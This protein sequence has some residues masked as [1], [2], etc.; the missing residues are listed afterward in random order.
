DFSLHVGSMVRSPVARPFNTQH[1][2][3]RPAGHTA[4][5]HRQ[6]LATI[7]APALTRLS[8]V[9]E[10]VMNRIDASRPGEIGRRQVTAALALAALPPGASL[11]ERQFNL[12]PPV[13][14]IATQIFDLHT[15]IVWICVVIF[16]GVFSVMFYSIFA[17]RKSKGH[18][19]AQFHE[20]TLVEI[21]WTAIPFLILMF[22]AFPA[23]KTVL[24]MKDSWGPDMTEKTRVFQGRWHYDSPAQGFWY[25]STRAPPQAQIQNRE[26]RGEHSRLEVNQ[27]MVVPGGKRVGVLIT[28]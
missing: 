13:T 3:V 7:A 28:A 24:A 1:C 19:A 11:A 12:P 10:E 20:N 2:C 14:P 25:R 17:H 18:Q 9:F 8:K 27:R 23:T 4:A 6:E 22:M 16:V 5:A 21:V 26:A 15:Y